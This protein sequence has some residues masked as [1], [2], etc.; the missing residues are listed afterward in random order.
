MGLPF[1]HAVL[2]GAYEA[3]LAAAALLAHEHKKRVKVFL[4]ALGGG[5]FGNRTSWIA[6]ALEKSLQ[7]YRAEPLDVF[8]VH[9]LHLPHGG[10]F[11]DVEAR[12]NAKRAQKPGTPRPVAACVV[13]NSIAIRKRPAASSEL[14]TRSTERAPPATIKRPA[15][16]M[17]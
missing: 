8:L 9:Y 17:A 14:R 12:A 5:A 1:A 10:P 3:T 2:E 6:D 4:T 15:S 7:A 16:G 11:I 13:D